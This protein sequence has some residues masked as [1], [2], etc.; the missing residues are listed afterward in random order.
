MMKTSRSASTGKDLKE[1]IKNILIE[2]HIGT[3][4]MFDDEDLECM[5][6]DIM[7]VIKNQPE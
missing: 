6:D 2:W 7:K 3:E 1:D 5:T 4:D